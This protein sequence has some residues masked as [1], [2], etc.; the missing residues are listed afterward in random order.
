[1]NFWPDGVGVFATVGCKRISQ[2]VDEL[3][4]RDD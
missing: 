4:Y 3:L 2:K 1:M